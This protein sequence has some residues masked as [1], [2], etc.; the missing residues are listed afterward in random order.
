MDQCS[1]KSWCCLAGLVYMG[2][3]LFDSSFLFFRLTMQECLEELLPVYAMHFSGYEIWVHICA[4]SLSSCEVSK[5]A[6]PD[7][8]KQ[9]QNSFSSRQVRPAKKLLSSLY[10]RA[11]CPKRARIGKKTQSDRALYRHRNFLEVAWHHF[12]LIFKARMKKL[13]IKRI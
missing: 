10:I 13:R 12:C 8:S 3:L 2:T 4:C 5:K 6:H 11:Q 1:K 9:G 7:S